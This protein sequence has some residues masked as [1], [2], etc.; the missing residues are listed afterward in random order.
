MHQDSDKSSRSDDN[1]SFFDRLAPL[2]KD[3]AWK[4]LINLDKPL[5]FPRGRHHGKDASWF[6]SHCN[7]THLELDECSQAQFGE[8]D[9][10]CIS[11]NRVHRDYVNMQ[12]TL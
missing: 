2:Y 7:K 9:R 6:C 12:L 3:I 4:A 11:C 1:L 10:W 5:L 8:G